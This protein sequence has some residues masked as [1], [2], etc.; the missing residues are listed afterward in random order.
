MDKDKKGQS[1]NPKRRRINL[2]W[3]SLIPVTIMVI[4][5]PA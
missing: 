5:A 2:R 3:P 4:A 1:M